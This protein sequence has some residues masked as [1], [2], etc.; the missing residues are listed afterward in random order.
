[1]IRKTCLYT[2]LEHTEKIEAAAKLLKA[3]HCTTEEIESFLQEAVI[4]R[5]FNHP[6]VLH[7]IGVVWEKGQL[8]VVI[9]P[10]MGNGDL[11]TLVRKQDIV[12]T[13]VLIHTHHALVRLTK[14]YDL[15]LVT[16]HYF[17]LV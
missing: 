13:A 7:L 1:M 12:S 17:Y 8:P 6:N 11:R 5:R 4:M 14:I 3:T 10:F 15:L 16:A 2:D 9:L